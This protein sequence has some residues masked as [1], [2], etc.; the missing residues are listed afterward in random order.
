MATRGVCRVSV[1][2]YNSRYYQKCIPVL[3][4]I[5]V[6]RCKVSS[7]RKNRV[8]V[9]DVKWYCRWQAWWFVYENRA[10]LRIQ[11]EMRILEKMT[12]LGNQAWNENNESGMLWVEEK[13]K[14][15]ECD[16]KIKKLKLKKK[17]I[18]E[19][20]NV[21]KFFLLPLPRDW[22]DLIDLNRL[23]LGTRT[24]RIRDRSIS[25][26]EKWAIEKMS[27][28]KMNNRKIEQSRKW[29]IEKVKSR[30]WAYWATK[31]WTIEK[32][33]NKKMNNPK[34]NNRKIEQSRK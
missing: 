11:R 33:S 9:W 12:E 29:A 3:R 17:K 8:I 20:C 2:F 5:P 19:S 14:I 28:Q 27:N 18:V 16:E 7:E 15:N 31:K 32:T 1:N 21:W 34:I 26:C 6:M 30:N 23:K 10:F 22:I 13:F 25:W 24:Y 4:K